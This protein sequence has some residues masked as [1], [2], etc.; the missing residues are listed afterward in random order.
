MI[1]QKFGLD[2]NQVQSVFDQYRQQQKT[3]FQQN[4]QNRLNSKLDQAVQ[5]GKITSTQKQA[6]LDELATL[7]NKYNLNSLQ[8]MTPAQ[9]KQALQNAQSDFVSWAKSQ[10]INLSNLKIGFGFG[11]PFLLRG[12]HMGLITTPTPTP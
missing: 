6:I 8:T 7:K 1:A 12:R 3:N 5:Q 10:G 4:L 2:K 9:R 11:M